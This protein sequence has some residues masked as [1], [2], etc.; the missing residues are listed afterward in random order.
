MRADLKYTV[1]LI[2]ACLGAGLATPAAAQ[3]GVFLDP[4]TGDYT[5][6]YRGYGDALGDVTFY[7]H[8]KIDPAVKSKIGQADDGS[9]NY[10]YRVKN[11][12]KSKQN[13]ISL[14]L[15]SM[16]AIANS[17]N[18]LPGWRS[19]MNLISSSH[20]IY[21]DAGYFVS[22]I[23][24][25]KLASNEGITT[26]G[27]APG[28]SQH[29]EFR[30][31]LL[32]GVGIMSLRGSAPITEY[33]DEG[34]DPTSAVGIELN[35]LEQNDFVPRIAAVPRI[36]VPIPYSAVIVLTNIQKHLDTDL[37]S[38]KLVEPALV[39]ELD[40]WLGAA[41]AAAGQ[42]NTQALRTSLQEARK[43]LKREHADIDKDDDRD[44]DDK[45]TQIKSRIDKLAARVLDFDLRY[46]ENRIKGD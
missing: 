18:S 8:T 29:F 1:M 12:E 35:K 19:G 13:L 33:P 43:L 16:H 39:T 4:V 10:L 20:P 42:G 22:W 21:G 45:P 7:P 28:A 26:K 6:R 46:V 27:L 36:P 34:P 41:I 5:I 15:T 44:E 31:L 30:S 38:M 25:N 2:G 11:G 23:F 17:Q 37:I 3:E 24:L 40:R 32:P 14:R 9:I